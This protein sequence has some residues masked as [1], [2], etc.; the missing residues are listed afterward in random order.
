[1]INKVVTTIGKPYLLLFTF[2]KGK[3]PLCK[4]RTLFAHVA[5]VVLFSHIVWLV[6]SFIAYLTNVSFPLLVDDGIGGFVSVFVAFIIGILVSKIS[7]R[8]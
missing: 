2:I 3:E 7:L 4:F 8:L 5:S 1:M 6:L